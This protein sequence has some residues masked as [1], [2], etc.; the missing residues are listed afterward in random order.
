M[1]FGSRDLEIHNECFS[2]G[3]AFTDGSHRKCVQKQQA[4]LLAAAIDLGQPKVD[5]AALWQAASEDER[6]EALFG[7]LSALYI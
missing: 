4:V 6:R 7:H 1:Y 3:G 5:M 2:S